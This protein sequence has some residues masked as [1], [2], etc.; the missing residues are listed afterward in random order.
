MKAKKKATDSAADTV[1]T[2]FGKVVMKPES[3]EVDTNKVNLFSFVDSISLT[4][5]YIYSDETSREYNPWVVNRAFMIHTDTLYH[6]AQMNHWHQLDKKMH[7]DYLFHS[8]PKKKRWKKWLKQSEEEK[9][10]QR[11]IE[12]VAK[13]LNYNITRTKQAWALMTKEQ[14]EHMLN[15]AFPD[16]KNDKKSF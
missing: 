12:A 15:L 10:N 4:K 13:L 6:A 2:L 1:S 9:N 7:H 8:L 16:R 14:K 5:D 3:V 11:V